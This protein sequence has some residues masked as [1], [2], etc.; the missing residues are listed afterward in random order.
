VRASE[1]SVAQQPGLLLTFAC[2]DPTAPK[3][4][5][6]ALPRPE[7]PVSS[8]SRDPGGGPA[9]NLVARERLSLLALNLPLLALGFR[10]PKPLVFRIR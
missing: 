2:A 9:E 5:S 7:T 6:R 8:P 3:L 4:N 1:A 10:K